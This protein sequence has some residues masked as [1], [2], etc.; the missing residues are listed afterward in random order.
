V[1][2]H[3][4]RPEAYDPANL[5]GPILKLAKRYGL[6]IE[7]SSAGWRKKVGE[8]YPHETILRLANEYGVPITTASDAHS[9]AQVGEDYE[10]LAAVLERAGVTRTATFWQHKQRSVDE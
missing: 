5:F 4:L 8:Q 9:Y 7:A 3:D 6:A 2:I 10:R 1:K